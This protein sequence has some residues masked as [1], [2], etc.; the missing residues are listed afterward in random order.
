MLIGDLMQ[1]HLYSVLERQRGAS[2]MLPLVSVE[3]NALIL[4]VLYKAGWLWI[5]NTL[6]WT[7]RCLLDTE[8]PSDGQEGT[9][10][11]NH[12]IREHKALLLKHQL[13]HKHIHVRISQWL[14]MLIKFT[15]HLNKQNSPK[16]EKSVNKLQLKLSNFN[17]DEYST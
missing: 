2:L 1:V 3:T 14:P 4:I 5:G 9:C 16:N 15:L 6:H 13:T 7:Q 12:T 17:K 8:S 11:L 10:D